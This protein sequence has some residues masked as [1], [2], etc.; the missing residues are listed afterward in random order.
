MNVCEGLNVISIERIRCVGFYYSAD[1]RS[2]GCSISPW[3]QSRV[4]VKAAPLPVRVWIPAAFK[5]DNDVK[6][7]MRICRNILQNAG[8]LV[9]RSAVDVHA[10]DFS[11]RVFVTEIFFGNRFCEDYRMNLVQSFLFA[12]ATKGKSKTSKNCWSTRISS[13]S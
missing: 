13:V 2:K 6:L 1:I 7:E 11:H 9:I 4:G 10:D 8:H 5:R 12:P 3:F